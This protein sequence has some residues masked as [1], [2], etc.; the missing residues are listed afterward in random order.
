MW[1]FCV[2]LGYPLLWWWRNNWMPLT[3]LYLY[4]YSSQPQSLFALYSFL[5]WVQTGFNVLETFGF[6]VFTNIE[7][8]QRHPIYHGLNIVE[9]VPPI[10]KMLW[11]LIPGLTWMISDFTIILSLCLNLEL[12]KLTWY[13]R[14]TT[15]PSQRKVNTVQSNSTPARRMEK[16]F[17]NL[18]GNLFKTKVTL[19][20]THELSVFNLFFFSKL[21]WLL[22]YL[23]CYRHRWL[24]GTKNRTMGRCGRKPWTVQRL[25]LRD[26]WSAQVRSSSGII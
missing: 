9:M 8:N 10:M 24:T 18:S 7:P 11:P 20:R 26:P 12:I 1:S 2:W 21:N 6:F 16:F 22:I 14:D 4:S 3:F 17:L 19:P 5:R 15:R 23:I 25:G 13:L